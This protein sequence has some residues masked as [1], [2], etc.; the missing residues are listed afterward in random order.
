MALIAV[1]S[2]IGKS[3]FVVTATPPP[4]HWKLILYTQGPELSKPLIN[5]TFGAAV[6]S[7]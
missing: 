4:T 7:T 2:G 1:A 6:H 3:Y 5:Y